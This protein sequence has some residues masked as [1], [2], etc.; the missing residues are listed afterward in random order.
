LAEFDP[1]AVE[2]GRV[3]AEALAV[4]LEEL[5]VSEVEAEE[6]L[7]QGVTLVIGGEKP[8]DPGGKA[9]LAEHVVQVGKAS[10]DNQRRV[11]RRRRNPEKLAKL[12][13]YTDVPPPTP[14]ELTDER[15]EGDDA[16]EKLLAAI[17]DD[18]ELQ[19]LVALMRR[20]ID[21]AATQAAELGWKIGRV[22]NA[23]RRL[24]EVID[25]LAESVR[26]VREQEPEQEQ[27]QGQDES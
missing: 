21:D 22:Y 8:F 19:A 18:A 24:K 5:E 6:I 16:F 2:W 27:E 23:R 15:E 13:H 17:Q 4:A 25:G 3:Y 7:Q 1:A 10:R 14:E 12:E 26:P 11:E 20:D 9:T